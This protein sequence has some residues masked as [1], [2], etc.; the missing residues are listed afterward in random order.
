MHRMD[1]NTSYSVEMIWTGSY[2]FQ[3]PA[4]TRGPFR[5]RRRGQVHLRVR[6]SPVEP[7][8]GGDQEWQPEEDRTLQKAW[9]GALHPDGRKTDFSGNL[10]GTEIVY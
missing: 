5:E 9:N 8:P 3:V 10:L 2:G 6:R 4:V 1:S 7:D